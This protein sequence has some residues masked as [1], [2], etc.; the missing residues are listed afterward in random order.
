MH[1]ECRLIESPLYKPQKD[2]GDHSRNDEMHL[3]L[4]LVISV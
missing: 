1:S 3:I 4:N 2:V